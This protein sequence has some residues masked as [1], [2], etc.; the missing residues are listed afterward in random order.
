MKQTRE[1]MNKGAV[2]GIIAV[3]VSV[4]LLASM[5]MA[6]AK[7]YGDANGDGVIDEDDITHVEQII[8][9]EK[10]ENELADVNQDGEI[11]VLDI[12]YIELIILGTA[13]S[14]GGTLVVAVY[15]SS[16]TPKHFEEAFGI[17]PYGTNIYEPLVSLDNDMNLQPWLAK[18]WERMD[19]D[20]WRFYLREDV[21]FHDGTPFNAKAAKFSFERMIDSIP[22]TARL[23]IDRI[24]AVDDYTIDITNKRPFAMFPAYAAH[25]WTVM[26]SQSVEDG[27]P[28]GTGPFRFE[29]LDKV[30]DELTVVKNREYRGKRPYLDKVIF[31]N[32]PDAQT[33]VLALEAG[34]VDLIQEVQRSEVS[35]LEANPDITVSRAL[36]PGVCILGFNRQNEALSD[37]R[38]RKAI[39]HGIDKESI[40]ENVLSGVGQPA[41][42]IIS[43]IISWSAH[44]ELEGHPYNTAKTKELLSDAGWKDTDGDGYLDKGGKTLELNLIFDA[45][46]DPDNEAMAEA[47]QG[48]LRDVGIKVDLERVE[49]MQTPIKEGKW[50]MFIGSI[51]V[52]CGDASMIL[53]AWFHSEGFYGVGVKQLFPISDYVEKLLEEGQATADE[54]VY[55]QKFREVQ[56]IA[57]DEE[58]VL[59]PIFYPVRVCAAK[60][61]VKG[62]RPHPINGWSITLENTYIAS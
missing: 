50:D 55:S 23:A 43:P 14:I 46:S 8:A 4:M 57:I 7:L 37:I 20:T 53:H 49:S 13:H 54:T 16:W 1:K 15:Q 52:Y 58:V 38:V 17:T 31:R 32:I 33:R 39:C 44:D 27:E 29:K 41:K 3:I 6:T 22:W 18:S 56:R 47:I 19:D 26:A 40:V 24:T 30:K 48:Q 21:K 25:S 60:N 11:D 28:C 2:L 59:D 61:S 12:A 5:P 51:G 36:M 45:R 62:F 42:T 10:T 9:G 34:E 35:I